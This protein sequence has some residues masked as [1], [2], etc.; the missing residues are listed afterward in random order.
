[1]VK[2]EVDA[3]ILEKL[4]VHR[5]EHR[6][7]L[8]IQAFLRNCSEKQK[9]PISNSTGL[10]RV[11][12]FISRRMASNEDRK[13][14]EKKVSRRSLELASESYQAMLE[15]SSMCDVYIIEQCYTVLGID[16]D[17]QSL[18]FSALQTLVDFEREV[19]HLLKMQL[20]I[21]Y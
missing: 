4:K 13:S 15:N 16:P 11:V 3:S 5:L 18:M 7:A 2:K 21:N 14:D 9:G 6:A 12:G 10:N 17:T 1:M 8:K 19:C 20:N